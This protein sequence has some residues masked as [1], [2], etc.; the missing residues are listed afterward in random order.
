MGADSGGDMELMSFQLYVPDLKQA[1]MVKRNF[2]QEPENVYRVMLALV[3][4]NHELVAEILKDLAV[5][6]GLS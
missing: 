6:P 3:T 4:G 1:R 2:H 5:P